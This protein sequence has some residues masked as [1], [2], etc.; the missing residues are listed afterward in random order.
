MEGR[1]IVAVDMIPQL[2]DYF[3]QDI[4]SKFL[5]MTWEDESQQ[6]QEAAC[7]ALLSNGFASLLHD[8]LLTRLDSGQDRLRIAALGRLGSF[9]P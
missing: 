7:K 6:V 4:A 1:R 9:S 8:S 3:T 2:T 5:A